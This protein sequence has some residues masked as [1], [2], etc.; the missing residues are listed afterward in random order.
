MFI[1]WIIHDIYNHFVILRLS[2]VQVLAGNVHIHNEIMILPL[3]TGVSAQYD[4]QDHDDN[5][6]WT[7]FPR[8]WPF[9]WGIHRPSVNSPHNGQW[10]GALMFSLICAWTN[11]WVQD[12]DAG[13][14]RGHRAHH[15]VVV[16]WNTVLSVISCLSI[17]FRSRL[18]C[19][20]LCLWRL[21]CRDVFFNVTVG[22]EQDNCEL[23]GETNCGLIQC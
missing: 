22:P 13:D 9:V 4:A 7:H 21:G 12:R 18:E 15:D 16:M 6:K 2:P 3:H 19:S 10:R 20:A 17:H 14:L 11:C 23:F 1:S 5:I 8:Y